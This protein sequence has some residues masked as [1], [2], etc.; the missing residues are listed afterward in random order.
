MRSVDAN[1]G[2]HVSAPEFMFLVLRNSP[3]V[4]SEVR[5]EQGSVH[6]LRFH[7]LL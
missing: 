3:Y 4:R 5:P 1:V 6:G 2:R 7:S